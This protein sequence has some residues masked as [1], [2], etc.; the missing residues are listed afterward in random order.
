M[1]R[2]ARSDATTRGLWAP[3]VD[4]GR[5]RW[6]V[7]TAVRMTRREAKAE[8]L[9]AYPDEYRGRALSRVTFARVFIAEESRL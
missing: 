8:Y 2:K 9:S 4:S 1:P 7:W 6:I 3:V 5:T